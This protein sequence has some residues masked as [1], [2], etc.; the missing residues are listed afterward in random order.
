MA[1]VK[2]PVSASVQGV[3]NELD[4]IPAKV[5]AVSRKLNKF[6]WQVID[7]K[8]VEADLKKLEGM[9]ADFQ[10]KT[11]GLG[12]GGGGVPGATQSP[13]PLYRP[14]AAPP[15]P[16]GGG[17]RGGRGGPG[18]YTHAP[19]WWDAGRNLMGGFGGG[20]G[21]IG[22]Y[23][24]RGGL[25]GYHT[26]GVGGAGMG[27]LKGLG[28]GALAYG[29]FKVG[30]AVNEGHEMAKERGGSLDTIKRQM[31]DLGVSFARLK[32][33]SDAAADGLALNSVE[34][35]KLME[36]F[37]RESRGADRTPEDLM[38]SVRTSVGVSKAYGLDPG[39]GT[40]FFG[41]MRNIDPKQNNRELAL[42]LGET[43]ERSGMNARADEVMQV[44]QSFAATTSRMSLSAPN[45]SAHAGAYSSLMSSRMPGMTSDVASGILNQ[46]NSS[47]MGMGGAGEAGQNFILAAMQRNGGL[48]PI[49]AKALAA[50]G[51]FGTRAGVFGKDSALGRY[52]GGDAAGLAGGAGANVTNFDAIRNHLAGMGGD[53]WLQLEGAQRL[54][55]LSS[56][57]Q[58][59]ALLQMNSGEFGGLKN[60]LTRAGVGVNDFNESGI[61]TLAKIGSAGSMQGLNSIYASM[62]G[63]T[64][65]G[66]LTGDEVSALSAAQSTGDVEKFRDALIKIAATKDRE[67][68]Q[69]TIQQDQKALLEQIKL[70]TG[71]KLIPLTQAI[72]G[73]INAL[74]GK[75]APDSAYMK[76]LAAPST[77][78]ASGSWSTG[79]ATGSWGGGATGSKA[80]FIK[81]HAAGAAA[82]AAELGVDPKLLLAQAGLETGW[83]KSV[84]PGS[85]NLGNIKAGRGWSG[86]TASA[87][88]K[89]TGSVDSYRSYSST[90]AYWKDYAALIKRRYPGVVGSGSSAST[91]AQ[92][93]TAGGYAEDPAYAQ[94]LQDTYGSMTPL[95]SGANS[96]GGG[97]GFT[98]PGPVE[99]PLILLP[100]NQQGQSMGQAATARV[101]IPRGAGTAR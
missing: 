79:G 77:G 17:G 8:A 52:F 45:V 92:G 46:A 58:A 42:I 39:A 78:G 22:G 68:T 31:G 14:P 71:D 55:G 44:V 82:A 91:F 59:A 99:V 47:I 1:D 30:Q 63:R 2:I 57:Q 18:A 29:A 54:Y 35:A 5:E 51:L 15:V 26:G 84:I 100:Q 72:S 36:Q 38:R 67:E 19:Q 90:D 97:R 73:G 4:K 34:S 49:Q 53:K 12:F 43:I 16:P 74:V 88:D 24:V 25:S 28:V 23:G 65:K 64:G 81:Q 94:K 96:A 20:F 62:R 98:N 6:K 21:Q 50:G 13:G 32:V 70:N 61:Q 33:M 7:L 75:L 41:G 76:Q 83:G 85:N 60:S 89:M 3:T 87:K 27:L 9:V 37:V 11:G 101:S 95:P 10:K 80:D 69:Y 93:L 40:S 66:S 56:P 86:A 48:N